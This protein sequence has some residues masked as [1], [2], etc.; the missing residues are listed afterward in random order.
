[1]PGPFA[2][3]AFGVVRSGGTKPSSTI[4]ALAGNGSPVTLPRTIFN[5]PAAQAADEIEL[6]H[7]VGR[8]QPPKKK[9]IGSPP[10]TIAAGSGSPRLNALVAVDAPVV[11]GGHHH[12]TVFLSCTCARYAPALSQF[13]SG[14]RVMV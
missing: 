14:S 5:R 6:E 2:E 1:V 11:T 13:S 9:A 10:S 7:A 4:S 3:R 8:F 12:A